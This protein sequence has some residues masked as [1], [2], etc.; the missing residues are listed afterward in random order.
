MIRG[1]DTKIGFFRTAGGDD[2]IS[3]SL[4]VDPGRAIVTRNYE[5]DK[6]GRYRLIDGY[7][8][9]DGRPS[10][11]ESSYYILDFV[12]GQVEP[13]PG[14]IVMG[15]TSAA[16][17]TVLS[18][19]L[20]SGGWTL[21]DAEGYIVLYS[22]T[23]PYSITDFVD[24]E[25]LY[26]GA[27][28]VGVTD[29]IARQGGADSDYYD[30]IY[31][32]QVI[33]A[34]R[35][36]IEAVPGSGDILG[37]WL[38]NDVVY[39]FRNNLTGTAALMYKSTTSGWIVC[40]LGAVISFTSGGT[41][42]ILE[43]DIITGATSTETAEV[44]RVILESGSWSGGDAAGRL[45]LYDQSGSFVSENLN[46][47]A[48][49]NVA[50]IAGDST[51]TTLLPNGKY[52]FFN[53]N[54][55]G[56]VGQR[57][58]YGCD[59][60]NPAFEW[61]SVTFTQ[62]L[63]GMEDDS[64]NHIIAHK[65]HLFLSFP[66]GSLQFSS[67]PADPDDPV[68]PY[69]WSVITGA[70][71]IGIGDEIT[72]LMSMP[73]VLVVFS[74]NSTN[75]LYSTDTGWSMTTHSQEAGAIE[76]TVQKIGNGVYLDDRGITTLSTTDAYGDFKSNSIS[77]YI[78]PYLTEQLNNVVASVRVKEKNQYRLFMQNYEVVTLTLDGSKVIG[79]SRQY[80]NDRVTCCSSSEDSNGREKMY[81]GSDDGFVYQ[82]DKGTSFNGSAIEALIKFHFNNLRSPSKKKRI[83][84]ITMELDA[85]INTYLAAE[86]EYNYGEYSNQQKFFDFEQPGG[87]WG[88][89]TWG[90]F[91]WGGRSVASAPLYCDG[92][93]ENF[94]ITVYHSGMWELQE[95]ESGFPITF[96]YTFAEVRSGLTGALPHTIQGYTVHYIDR[97]IKR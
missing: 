5:C 54:F 18:V 69:E 42:E 84:K 29:G 33:E 6:N 93:C 17:G 14:D 71:E 22:E 35:S 49:T 3:S 62:I 39:A 77:K 63:T 85:P 92:T 59:G 23:Y 15:G 88:V 90:A 86:I 11:S 97:G 46:V 72:G 48:T 82:L 74:R 13:L 91:V 12:S 51:A 16:T 89:D 26:V 37:V 58:M 53:Y 60:Q 61:D 81:F 43:G 70:G 27:S 7:E 95:E 20:E 8:A 50:T 56:S 45:I 1:S 87:I 4:E 83:K 57:R 67:L 96:P 52:E 32:L 80:Y 73:D 2:L 68:Y 34:V 38:F 24:G 55:G 79:F 47:G 65:G 44:R 75:L 78:D 9:F 64:P 25:D 19:V 40:D 30:I 31:Q 66:G 94:S 36:N 41:Y 28:Y 76:W 10:P 21:S